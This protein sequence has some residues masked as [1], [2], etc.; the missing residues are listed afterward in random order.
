MSV[1]LGL[2]IS[3]FKVGYSFDMPMGANSIFGGKHEVFVNYCFKISLDTDKN[4]HKSTRF[5]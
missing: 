1:L 5:L 4:Y 3:N 2:N